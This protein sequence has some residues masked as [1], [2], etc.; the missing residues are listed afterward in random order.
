MAGT[1]T[2]VV[3]IR[4]GSFLLFFAIAMGALGLVSQV[5]V[6]TGIMAV[7]AVIAVI[8][9]AVAVHRQSQRENEEDD[10]AGME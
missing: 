8:D 3:H 9:I 5:P 4:L 7:V 2:D 6:L 1:P 10:S